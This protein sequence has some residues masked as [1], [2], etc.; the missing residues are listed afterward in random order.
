MEDIVF[1]AMFSFQLFCNHVFK[2]KNIDKLVPK[3]MM[4]SEWNIKKSVIIAEEMESMHRYL[5]EQAAIRLG[6]YP[7]DYKQDI[8]RRFNATIGRALNSYQEKLIN[9]YP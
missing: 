2:Q 7:A 4:R 5:N 8:E 1:N 6:A 3:G 9:Y